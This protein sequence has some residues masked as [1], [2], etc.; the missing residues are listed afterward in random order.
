[1]KVIYYI[2][3]APPSGERCYG[4]LVSQFNSP[5]TSLVPTSRQTDSQSDRLSALVEV[6]RRVEEHLQSIGAPCLQGSCARNP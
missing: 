3:Q 2:L 4:A 1:M 5:Q 6:R